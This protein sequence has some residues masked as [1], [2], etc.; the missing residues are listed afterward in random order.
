MQLHDNRADKTPRR[1]LL[2]HKRFVAAVPLADDAAD[3]WAVHSQA[4]I[5]MLTS[6]YIILHH[7]LS[8]GCLL[9]L[10]GS[11][12]LFVTDTKE[13]M[14]SSRRR[15]GVASTKDGCRML[16]NGRGAHR[17]LLLPSLLALVVCLALL[18]GRVVADDLQASRPAPV[19]GR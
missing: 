17:G 5:S 19:G 4:E 6:S 15:A 7:N 2:G 9:G 3:P 14:D 18:Q 1:K 11:S 16:R 12:R 10:D 8:L 13:D